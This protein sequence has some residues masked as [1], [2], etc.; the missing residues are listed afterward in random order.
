MAITCMKINK[1]SLLA[2]SSLEDGRIYKQSIYIL[3]WGLC[4]YGALEKVPF[5]VT[6]NH[7]KQS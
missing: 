1:Y 7:R 5:S 3:V 6:E 4:I 2:Y